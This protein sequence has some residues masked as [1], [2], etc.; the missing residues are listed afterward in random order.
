MSQSGQ[1]LEVDEDNVQGRVIFLTDLNRTLH[2]KH[3]L[4]LESHVSGGYSI[5][6]RSG[7]NKGLNQH[8]YQA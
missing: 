3:I 8:E 1:R 2:G 7:E 5:S 6:I 4:C